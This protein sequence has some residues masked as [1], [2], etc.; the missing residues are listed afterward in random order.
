MND[1]DC[2]PTASHPVAPHAGAWIETPDAPYHPLSVSSSEPCPAAR[3]FLR[4]R[5]LTSAYDH[6]RALGAVQVA[7]NRRNGTPTAR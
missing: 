4:S 7:T 6:A 2:D 1:I 3:A 5:R